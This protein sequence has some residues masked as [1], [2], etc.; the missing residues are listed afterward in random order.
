MDYNRDDSRL[1][2]SD[3]FQHNSDSEDELWRKFLQEEEAIRRLVAQGKTWT[4][5]CPNCGCIFENDAPEAQQLC[6]ECGRKEI[7]RIL[8]KRQ[9]ELRE[10]ERQSTGRS[11]PSFES[12]YARLKNSGHYIDDK[13]PRKWVEFWQ[14]CEQNQ[15]GLGKL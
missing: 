15:R 13:E 14:M 3:I 5:T 9:Q 7:Q 10:M 8:D 4:H 6:P 11:I 1:G 2:R 12:E